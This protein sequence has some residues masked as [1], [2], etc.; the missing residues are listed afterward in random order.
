MEYIFLTINLTL[1][2]IDFVS[3]VFKKVAK[4]SVFEVEFI[5]IFLFVYPFTTGQ[6][7]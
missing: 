4:P 6:T 1:R 3:K 5:C 2:D 7:I